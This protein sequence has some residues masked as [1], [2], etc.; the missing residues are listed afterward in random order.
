TF[1][2]PFAPRPLRRFIA[3]M[4]ALTADGAA[5]RSFLRYMNTVL[6]PISSPCF[7]HTTFLTIPSPTTPCPTNAALPHY[8]SAH[9]FV[10]GFAFQTQAR[11]DIK[12]SRVRFLRT[13][14]SSSVVS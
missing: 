11:R 7:T 13:G 9:R 5:L 3:T 10:L 1:L 8:P 4:A 2:P 6:T 14:R 12:P